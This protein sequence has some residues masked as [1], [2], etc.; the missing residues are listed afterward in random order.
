MWNTL[1]RRIDLST[2]GI[3]LVVAAVSTHG[4][5]SWALMMAAGMALAAHYWRQNSHKLAVAFLAM[6]IVFGV[7]LWQRR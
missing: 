7:V 4:L 1:R 5:L 2:I 3:L 6:M